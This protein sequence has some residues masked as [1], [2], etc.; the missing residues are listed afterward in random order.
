MQRFFILGVALAAAGCRGASGESAPSPSA[1]ALIRTAPVIRERVARPLIA[2]GMLSPKDEI[3]LSFKVGGVV[4]RILVDDGSI[5][6]AGDT[7]ASLELSEIDAAVTRARSAAEKAERD[8]G[9]AD[10]LYRDS[11]V[12]LTQLQDTRT[13]AQVASADLDA[14]L[15]NRRYAVIT[16]PSSGV[17]LDRQAEPGELVTVGRTILSLGSVARGSVVRVGLADRDAVRIHRGDAAVVHFDALPGREFPG[18]VTEI[19]AAAETA[20][21]TFRVEVAIRERGGPASGLIGRVTIQPSEA[22]L[23]TV[24]PL[25]AV[26]EAD[27]DQASVF[28][29]SDDGASVSRRLVTLGSI[30]GDRVVVTRGLEG[31][32]SVVTAGAAYLRDG[33]AVREAR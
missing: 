13:A 15:F 1:P 5:V 4:N 8:L 3:A 20:T 2:T 9:R 32:R 14:A 23:A 27:G 31:V 30:A 19:A 18:R 17:I 11:V 10:R 22:I 33:Q 12:T 16:A 25:E 7:L 6:R 28:V 24:I 29:L 26:L 21:G